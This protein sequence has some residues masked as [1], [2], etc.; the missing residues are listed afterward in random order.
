M[1]VD[2]DG[3]IASEDTTDRILEC[4]ADPEWRAIEDQ[5]NAGRIG[6]RECMK[7]Q[8]DLVRARPEDIDAVLA[9]VSIDPYFSDFAAWCD[10]RGLPLTVVS[11]GLDR[12]VAAVLRAA[13][14]DLPFYANHFEWLGGK[15][16]QLSFPNASEECRVFS[17]NCKC[18]VATREARGLRVLIGDGQSDYCLAARADMVLSK[19]SLTQYCISEGITHSAFETFEDAREL[20]SSWIEAQSG[21]TEFAA[22]YQGEK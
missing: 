8:I 6:S 17:G 13:A 19:G 16:W 5:W 10:T 22:D 9:G 21:I 11:D 20:L 15:T 12:N 18:N 4:F 14:L 3:T 7:R 2:F 1:F